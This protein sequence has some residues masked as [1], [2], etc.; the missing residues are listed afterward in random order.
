M[1]ASGPPHKIE[2]A[3][4]NGFVCLGAT[5]LLE[6][7][8]TVLLNSSQG[9]QPT[10]D[11]PWVQR[12]L[13]AVESF[14]D[15]GNILFTSIGLNTWEW[16]CWAAGHCRLRQIVAV[17]DFGER[18]P[19]RI[20][21]E[22]LRAFDLEGDLTCAVLIP[23]KKKKPKSWWAGR[24]ELSISAAHLIVPISIR[25]GGRIDKLLANRSA[26][27]RLDDRFRT[28][29]S[30]SPRTRPLLAFDSVR[31]RSAVDPLYRDWIIHWTRSADGPWPGETSADYY[32]AVA[33]SGGEYSRSARRTLERIEEERRIRASSWRIRGRA[34]VVAL[35]AAPPSEATT[36][37]RWRSRYARYTIEPYG[38]AIRKEAAL[39]SGVQPA[40]YRSESEKD[41][42]TPSWRLQSPGLR[43]DWPA[44]KEY[45]HLRDLD[46]SGLPGESWQ[47]I[48]LTGY[49][50]QGGE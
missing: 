33:E 40:L 41:R 45:R 17:P 31:I 10:G 28:D 29:W 35:S 2:R 14:K 44:E 30:P 18:P 13:R 3:T 21:G 50:L 34:P 11:L 36:L 19:E 38:L 27:T 20:F 42:T 46:L 23:A 16:V 43:G 12:T 47:S 37:M 5:P 15:D 39:D 8:T 1:E 4:W 7:K 25:S 22:L 32:R 48:E 49:L 6:A 9:K 24:D 26:S